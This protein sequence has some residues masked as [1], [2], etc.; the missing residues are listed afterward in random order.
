MA[1]PSIRYKRLVRFELLACVRPQFRQPWTRAIKH[2]EANGGPAA[3][4]R[5]RSV[6]ESGDETGPCSVG[7][8]RLA[9][10]GPKAQFGEYQPT[11]RRV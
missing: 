5:A 10:F 11:E 4:G 9:S 8:T 6:Q 7:E 3:L 2:I 1:L